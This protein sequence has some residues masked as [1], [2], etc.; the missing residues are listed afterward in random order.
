M[1]QC[2]VDLRVER[3]ALF[4]VHHQAEPAERRLQRV[5]DRLEAA[6]QLPVLPRL[7]DSVEHGQQATERGRRGLLA[8]GGA[9]PVDAL[10]VVGV[11][12]LQSLQVGGPF[13][14][15]DLDAGGLLAVLDYLPCH[16]LWGLFGGLF[17]L[18]G[19]FRGVPFLMLVFWLVLAGTGTGAR[20]R[21]G[22]AAAGPAGTSGAGRL[23]CRVLPP[24][25][26]GNR[27]D[28]PVVVDDRT[29]ARLL[30]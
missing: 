14:Q 2:L 3:V 21:A 25:L 7:V 17:L 27:V 30:G 29:G 12:R 10:A 18:L 15:L 28:A 24:N 9:V 26:A 4:S 16:H 8:H 1:G 5:G 23:G 11:F 13:G 20:L 6:G 22:A 19:R